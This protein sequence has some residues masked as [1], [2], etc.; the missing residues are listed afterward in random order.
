MSG[1]I[2]DGTGSDKIEADAALTPSQEAGPSDVAPPTAAPAEPEARPVRKSAPHLRVVSDA[3]NPDNVDD[4]SATMRV[5]PYLRSVRE[6][7]NLD[8]S[9]VAHVTRISE[10]HLRA[11]EEMTPNAFEAPVYAIGAITSYARHLRLDATEIVRRYREESG[12]LADPVRHEIAPPAPAKPPP[13][14]AIVAGVATLIVAA[15]IGGFYL[16]T[17]SASDRDDPAPA[18][19]AQADR[20]EV[21]QQSTNDAIVGPTVERPPLRLVALRKAWIEVRAADGTKYR[22]RYFEAGE[23]YAPRV[24]AG[25]TITARDGDAFEWRL[26]D[27]SLGLLSED[28][29]PIYAQSVD[30]ALQREA[31]LSEPA[32]VSGSAD[33]AAATPPPA[34]APRRTT[35]RPAASAPAPA[36]APTPAPASPAVAPP[37]VVNTGPAD[38]ERGV[39]AIEPAPGAPF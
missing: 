14:G 13:V 16:A 11:I 4:A 25:W 10:A 29:G 5:G 26:G 30:L 6:S 33:P 17:Q 34:P 28:G 20:P 19:A 24:G 21:I 37:A 38:I 3:D 8:L 22:S 31:V 1:A 23:S 9:D 18:D 2:K 27:A 32:A 39:E 12:F 7:R 36:A 35:P 15:A